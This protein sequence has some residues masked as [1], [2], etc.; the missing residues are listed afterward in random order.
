MAKRDYYEVLGVEKGGSVDEIKKAYRKLAMKHHPDRNPGDK[1]AETKF[2]EAAEAY[3]VL[4]DEQKRQRYD[5]LGHAGVDG[6]G[7]AGQG[8][9][10]MED[11]FA[12][13]GDVFG[14]GSIFDGLFAGGGRGGGARNQGASLK[15]GLEITFREAIFGCTKTI[16]LKRNEPCET[17]KGSGAKA[18]TKAV[19]C[20]VCA[21]HGIVRQGQGFFVVQTTCPQCH[22]S[23]KFIPEPCPTCRGA[24]ASPK[25][26]TIKVRI[27]AGVEDSSRLRVAGEGEGGRDGGPR[28]DLYVYISVK[29]D[30]FF[31]RHE[32]DVVC[33]IPVGYAQ[34]ALGAEIEVPTLDG[35]AKLRIPAGTQPNEVLRMRGQGVPGRG[36]ARGDQLVVV[37]VTVPK[38]TTKRQEELLRELG[39]IEDASGEQ[40]SFFDRLKSVFE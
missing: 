39:T 8:F 23:G 16:D 21:G 1:D 27:P 25:K 13:F 2:K 38:R 30:P 3:E 26:V 7:H 18:G 32:D 4:S 5:Q 22:G 9:H 19:T 11:I 34:A 35:S 12:A 31:E 6:M 33:K 36:S 24:G 29:A 10:S 40:K 17:C 14:G 15:L 37:Q 28:G 20:T